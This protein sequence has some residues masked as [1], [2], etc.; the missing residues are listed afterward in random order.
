VSNIK[1]LKK[2]EKDFRKI[3]KSDLPRIFDKIEND[4]A[5]NPGKHKELKGN[6]GI[7]SY[8]VGFYRIIYTIENDCIVIAKIGHRRDVYKSLR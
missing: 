1:F 3:S 4:L 8:R 5:N 6:S 7:F 2:T